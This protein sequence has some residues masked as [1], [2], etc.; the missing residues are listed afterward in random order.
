MLKSRSSIPKK[1]RGALVWERVDG[2][3]YEVHETGLL[4]ETDHLGRTFIIAHVRV[5]G[6]A[7]VNV[8][9]RP[10]LRAWARDKAD[11]LEALPG[12]FCDRLEDLLERLS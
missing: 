12:D 5:G 11:R 8:Y 1:P 9:W 10:D 6:E 2:V 7:G 4:R 3:D